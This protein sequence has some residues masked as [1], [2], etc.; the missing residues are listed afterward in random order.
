MYK[1]DLIQNGLKTNRSVSPLGISIRFNYKIAEDIRECSFLYIETSSG[2]CRHKTL[3]YTHK[4]SVKKRN[5]ILEMMIIKLN[6]RNQIRS[7]I[8]YIVITC[9]FIKQ[10]LVKKF[11]IK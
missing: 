9:V 5:K 8:F 10:A 7:Q 11:W 1:N 2:S 6:R 4:C 3:N